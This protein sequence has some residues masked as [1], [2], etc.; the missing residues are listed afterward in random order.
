MTNDEFDIMQRLVTTATTQP[1]VSLKQ[2]AKT[3]YFD[4]NYFK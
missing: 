3:F 1:N 4:D 2:N